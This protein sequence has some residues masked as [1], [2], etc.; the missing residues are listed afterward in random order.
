MELASPAEH[1]EA[2]HG[3]PSTARRNAAQ[4]STHHVRNVA[5]ARQLPLADKG[6]LLRPLKDHGGGELVEH[7]LD[8]RPL[9]HGLQQQGRAG[10]DR[11]V[12]GQ[13]EGSS[14]VCAGHLA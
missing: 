10:A 12:S 9:Q 8:A 13:G 3:R 4:P 6:L 5:L 1:A 14:P 7:H 2:Q 11:W